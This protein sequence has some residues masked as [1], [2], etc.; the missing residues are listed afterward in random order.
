MFSLTESM[1]V[2]SEP[3]LDSTSMLPAFHEP[4]F[5]AKILVID[6]EPVNI[7][8]VLRL[9]RLEGYTQFV[10][11]S[12]ARQ[13]LEL[14]QKERPDLVLLDLMMPHISGLDI[15][16]KLRH[17]A[18]LA[19]TPTIILSATT[20]HDTRV[21]ALRTGANDFLNKPI[22]PSELIPRVGNL[23]VLKRHQ[24]RLEDYSRELEQAV[25]ERTAQLEASRRDILHCLARAAEF[26]DD[27]T[28]NHV[29]RVGRYA[30]LIAEGLGLG[31][32]YASDIEQAAQLHDVGKIGISD[33]VLKKPGKLTEE[34]FRL[35][36]KHA[37]LGKR[38]LQRLS[39]QMETA[40]RDHAHIGANVLGAANS[41]VLD[42]ASRIALTH[43]EW[44]DGTGYPLGLQ[45]EDIPL[46]GRITAVADVFDALSTKR[47]YKDAFP[48]EKCFQIMTDEKGRHFDPEILEAFFRKRKEIVEIQ[49][50][51][52]DDE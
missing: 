36:Q 38:V 16:R 39:P 29:I 8:V 17:D 6:D 48:L 1:P 33:D 18:T 3:K 9:L 42:M 15:L 5:D 20:D 26:R 32:R 11:T 40:L 51:C 28:G 10:S 22:D 24:D 34:E 31:P 25:R 4:A 50:H 45:G 44:W 19:H 7:K 49:M 13:G 14:I 35:M 46:E 23:L 2:D 27:D 41:P 43:H 30:R 12:D 52:A 47:C 21:E 37:N